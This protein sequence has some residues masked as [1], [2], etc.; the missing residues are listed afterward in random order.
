MKAQRRHKLAENELAR[1]IT[2]APSF[3]QDSGGKFLAACVAV[4][5][6]VILV[7]YRINSNRESAL[8][9]V[10]NL[11]TART[12]IEE[13]LR[14]PEVLGVF[15]PPQDAATRRRTLFN[16]ANDAIGRAMTLSD[17]KKIS[18]E[19]L[20]AKADLAWTLA[21]LPPLPGAATK[22]S[23]GLRDPN[24]LISSAAEAYQTIITN[25][26]DEKYA[27]IAARFG[28]AAIAENKGDFDAAK[29]H[30]EKVATEAKD[31]PA[32][33]QLAT[34]RLAMLDTLR[35]PVLLAPPATEPA[36]TTKPISIPDLIR[37][38]TTT[39]AATRP[40]AKPT[41]HP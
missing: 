9:A 22:P 10:Q 40:S 31:F 4:L 25:Y 11:A 2:K 6:I 17:D 16:D 33:Q 37:P 26:P 34:S 12:I 14:R 24:E 41:T 29:A 13:E 8:A 1:V 38:P 3:W 35:K 7:R 21:N 20:L 32:Y 36:A 28:L 39:P 27:A 15:T 5:V 19:A 23:L 30:Y 18:A